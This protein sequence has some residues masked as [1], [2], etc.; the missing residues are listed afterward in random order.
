MS[1][2]RPPQT[3]LILVASIKAKILRLQEELNELLELI[4]EIVI[5]K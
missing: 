2:D 3:N 1:E 4:E 5:Q